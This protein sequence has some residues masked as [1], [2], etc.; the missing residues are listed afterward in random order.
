MKSDLPT[1]PLFKDPPYRCIS[2][3]LV[4]RMVSWLA[5]PPRVQGCGKSRVCLLMD[6]WKFM[7]GRRG[8]AGGIISDWELARFLSTKVFRALLHILGIG[9]VTVGILIFVLGPSATLFRLCC[10]PRNLVFVLMFIYLPCPHPLP[11]PLPS[12]PSA[13][14]TSS[15]SPPSSSSSFLKHYKCAVPLIPQSRGKVWLSGNIPPRVI[16]QISSSL[17]LKIHQDLIGH[18]FNQTSMEQSHRI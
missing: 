3:A 1:R 9:I 4:R 15:S 17:S 11:A 13:S 8:K 6:L 12:S 7:V 2:W 18:P 5:R 14:L 10:R 16:Q